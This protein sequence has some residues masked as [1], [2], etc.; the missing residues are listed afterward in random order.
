M[1]VS[2]LSAV[3]FWP[4]AAA[5]L[6]LLGTGLGTRGL[7]VVRWF[8]VAASVIELGLVALT[9]APVI[10]ASGG[11]ALVENQPW[12]PL[13]GIGYHLGVD[14]I[15]VVLIALT[16]L[17]GFVVLLL[18]QAQDVPRLPQY[19]ALLLMTE[20]ASMGIFLSLDLILFYLFWE[21]VIIPVYL[22][23]AGWGGAR[24]RTAALRFLIM[25]FVGSL[26]M[27]VGMVALAAAA[28][29]VTGMF[30]FDLPTLLRLGVNFP[31]GLGYVAFGAFA[32]AFA[33]KTPLFPF[34]AWM[35]DAYTEATTPTTIALSS[36]L[37]KAGLYGFLRFL[38]PLF[39]LESAHLAPL[40]M[41]LGIGGVVYGSVIALGQQDMKRI[42]AFASLSHVGLITTGIFALSAI[43]IEGSVLQMMSHGIVIA[44]AFLIVGVVE[45]RTGRRDLAVLGGLQS[46]TPILAGFG[47]FVI[48]AVLGLP[49]LSSFSG[50]FLLIM[51]T[52]QRSIA[53]AI[54]AAVGIVLAAAYA[55]RLYQEVFHYD[56][57]GEKPHKDMFV[58]D[59]IAIVP[60]VLLIAYLGVAPG[61][62][63]ARVAPS[64]DHV[65][66]S[67]RHGATALSAPTRPDVPVRGVSR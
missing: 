39:P 49:G 29:Q 45:A 27:L 38:I 23:I 54:G 14:G 40:L 18:A 2:L 4:L 10:H 37:S 44:A 21:T 36:V 6:V 59:I 47:M 41:A 22:L 53:L 19:L 7:P 56:P 48:M 28:A 3:V 26:F 13:L 61:V 58:H 1:T 42:L 9:V 12:M 63:P 51:A 50:E 11:Y 62:V 8:A 57:G 60:L 25:S 31:S 33:I 46:R 17:I 34:H 66:T 52:F 16:A 32:L 67:A 20:A 30:T 55:L 24:R 15:S 43:G 5:L 64:L 65:L 35:P